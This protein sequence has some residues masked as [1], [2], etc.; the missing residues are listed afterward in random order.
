VVFWARLNGNPADLMRVIALGD[1]VEAAPPPE[2]LIA[3]PGV[4]NIRHQAPALHFRL[5]P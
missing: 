1:V 5:L 4:S 2:R 3:K